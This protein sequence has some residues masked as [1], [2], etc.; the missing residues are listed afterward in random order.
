M[1]F[2]LC[3]LCPSWEC[4]GSKLFLRRKQELQAQ[5]LLEYGKA[6]WRCTLCMSPSLIS[7]QLKIALLG[8]TPTSRSGTG[9]C[10]SH[11]H[12]GVGAGVSRA[13]L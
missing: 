5:S 13:G 2:R 8:C 3:E 11:P 4:S 9:A 1:V 12:L 10:L 6:A 7:F